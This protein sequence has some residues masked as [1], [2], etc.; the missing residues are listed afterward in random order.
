MGERDVTAP[1]AS[2][3]LFGGDWACAHGDTAG[4]AHVAKLLAPHVP[5]D[6]RAELAELARLCRSD[7][8]HACE[9][10]LVLRRMIGDDLVA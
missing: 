3:L 10:W 6:R 9:R 7:H 8:E 4:L 1:Q 2:A 5:A